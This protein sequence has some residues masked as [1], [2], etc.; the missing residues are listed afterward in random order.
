MGN[1]LA[2]KTVIVTG[3]TKGIG[4]GIAEMCAVEGAN[5]TVSG[6][7]ES[8]GLQVVRELKEKLGAKAV[9]AGGDISQE[10]TC[11]R[12]VDDTVQAFGRVDGLVNNAGIYPRSSLLNTTEELF[13]AVFA[14]NIKGAFFLCKYAVAS[15]IETGGGS[16]VHIGSTHGYKGGK[17][18]SPYAI[19]KGALLT[20]SRHIASNYSRDK[21]RSNWITVGWVASEG[22]IE[23]H[24]RMGK[25][26]EELIAFANSRIPSGRMQTPEDMAYGAVYLL[27]DESSQVT[28][29]EL[30]IAGG[31]NI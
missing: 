28:G 1:R 17:D 21:V 18:L 2:G 14:V 5:V 23:L 20:L 12:I 6:L 7:D 27:S 24:E 29:S 3:G 16:I 25:G 19:S 4:K 8:E 22:E 26:R 15:M 9:F 30:A 13:D 10:E 11:R 31:L